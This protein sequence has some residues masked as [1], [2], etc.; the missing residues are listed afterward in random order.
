MARQVSTWVFP[1]HHPAHVRSDAS[2]PPRL[3]V[4]DRPVSQTFYLAYATRLRVPGPRRPHP[5]KSDAVSIC[6]T[7]TDAGGRQHPSNPATP[8][9]WPGRMLFR[10]HSGSLPSSII[11]LPLNV[12][13]LRAAS[14]III[15]DDDSRLVGLFSR[16]LRFAHRWIEYHLGHVVQPSDHLCPAAAP[17]RCS[18]VPAAPDDSMTGAVN[19]R[20]GVP[21]AALI[22]ILFEPQWSGFPTVFTIC[23]CL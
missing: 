18:P 3:Y 6:R 19:E 17:E 2:S 22:R 21:A 14:E 20:A 5:L 8:R 11:V 10:H 9:R 7:G 4:D 1:T 16:R 13:R 12:R 15:D 23:C